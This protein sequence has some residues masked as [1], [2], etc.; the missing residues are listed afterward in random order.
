VR[1]VESSSSDANPPFFF[2]EPDNATLYSTL[3]PVQQDDEGFPNLSTMLYEKT[4]RGTI[5]VA[6]F[7]F[8][9]VLLV[10]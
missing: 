5:D 9:E 3:E 1:F 2:V 7:E 6:W 8:S 4:A 10:A